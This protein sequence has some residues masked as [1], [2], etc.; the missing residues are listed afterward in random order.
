[1]EKIIPQNILLAILLVVTITFTTLAVMSTK[2]RMDTEGTRTLMDISI[3]F[4]NR[5]GF[6]YNQ[7]NKSGLVAV[8]MPCALIHATG[9][10]LSKSEWFDFSDDGRWFVWILGSSRSIVASCS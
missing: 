2:V 3:P 10:V 8:V 1:M 4:N 7:E 6:V 9:F 5:L